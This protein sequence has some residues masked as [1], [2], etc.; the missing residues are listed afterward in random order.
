M[1]AAIGFSQGYPIE[2]TAP[3][4]RSAILFA[5]SE[6]HPASTGV[7][8]LP[9]LKQIYLGG[10]EAGSLKRELAAH[11]HVSTSSIDDYPFTAILFLQKTI[12][13]GFLGLNPS[14]QRRWVREVATESFRS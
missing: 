13:P 6:R 4:I 14:L 11:I 10:R 7:I 1:L 2:K 5:S 12:A 8:R 9:T 3:R